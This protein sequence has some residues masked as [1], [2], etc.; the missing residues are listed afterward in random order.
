[1]ERE[2][3][4]PPEPPRP[5]GRASW[6]ARTGRYLRRNPSLVWGLAVLLSLVLLWLV[7]FLAVDTENAR[8]LSV[9]PNQPPS[10]DHP[11]G[12]DRQGRDILAVLVVGAPLTLRIGLIAGTLGLIIGTVLA[13]VSAYYGGPL[14]VAIRGIVD[15]LQ[16]VP[17]LLVL[18]LIAIS[19]PSR[20]A[21][22]SVD[23]MALVVAAL[24]WLTPTRLIRAQVLVLRQ[25]SFV[26]LARLSGMRGPEIIVTEMMPSLMPYIVANFVLAVSSAIL[27][28]IGLEAL[29]LGP[30]EANT[31]GMTIYWNIYYTSI[32]HGLWWWYGPPIVLIVLLFVGLLLVTVGLDEWANPRLRQRV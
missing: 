19:M 11:L 9:R 27:A 20:Q 28:S 8:P 16:T 12:S 7:G 32:L 3:P 31:L 2:A 18:I 17:G 10:R 1:M 22:L 6:C 25:R 26:E 15:T 21:G 30:I 24:S 23:Q 13:F 4:A 14:D 29:G 5:A